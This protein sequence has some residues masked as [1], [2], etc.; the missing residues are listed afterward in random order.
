[1]NASPVVLARPAAFSRC[2]MAITPSWWSPRTSWMRLASFTTRLAATP[3]TGTASS[4]AYRA[5]L[6]ALRVSCRA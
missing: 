5:R 4:A 2:S 6:A 3:S 1:M